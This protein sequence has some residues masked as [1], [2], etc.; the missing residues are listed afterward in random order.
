MVHDYKQMESVFGGGENQ[1]D[2]RKITDRGLRFVFEAAGMASLVRKVKP[3]EFRSFFVQTMV[4]GG[5]PMP[6]ASQMVGH[7]SEK[8]TQGH[9]Y[10]LSVDRRRV[11]G[12]GIPV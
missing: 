1:R 2:S 9:Y 10:N 8:T 11:I 5:V 6:M 7:A 4:D 12:K 3:K